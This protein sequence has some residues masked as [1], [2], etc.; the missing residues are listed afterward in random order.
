LAQAL[1]EGCVAR[2][3]IV[4]VGGVHA[5]SRTHV[6][7]V[8]LILDREHH[9]VERADEPV[10]G[11]KMG[12]LLRRDFER[13]GHRRIV[14]RRICHASRF[15]R[16][17]PQL[18]SFGWPQIQ[19]HQG[20]ELM[21]ILDRCDRSLPEHPFRLVDACAVVGP[22][23]VQIELHHLRRRRFAAQ[24]RGLNILN[25]RFFDREFCGLRRGQRWR[26]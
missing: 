24:D 20:I 26:E 19:R 14:I 1:D 6:E 7:C 25:R 23:S 18:F 15:A 10:G 4:R 11:G 12:V 17:K 2:R 21:R 16:I 3:A 8:V 13:I 9:A 5:G 22:D